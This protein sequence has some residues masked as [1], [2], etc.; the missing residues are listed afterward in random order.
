MKQTSSL[1]N[2]EKTKQIT[3]KTANYLFV[4]YSIEEHIQ[5]SY[6][7]YTTFYYIVQVIHNTL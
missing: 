4:L 2:C 7:I 3:S 6:I 1:L 5:Y